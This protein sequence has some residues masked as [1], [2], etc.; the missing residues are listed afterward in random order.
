MPGTVLGA[1]Y[2]DLPLWNL[3]HSGWRR[4][5]ISKQMFVRCCKELWMKLKRG[6][7][8]ELEGVW[9]V[10]AGQGRPHWWDVSGAGPQGS[11]GGCRGIRAAPRAA[12]KTVEKVEAPDHLWETVPLKWVMISLFRF[13]SPFYH[14]EFQ[15]CATNE[16][17]WYVVWIWG[18]TIVFT[19]TSL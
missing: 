5:I 14:R 2:K 19:V 7:G 4:Q 8:L 13:W 6:K 11:E 12:K 16:K 3:L 9:Y 10:K 17:L 18:I 1:R 15:D